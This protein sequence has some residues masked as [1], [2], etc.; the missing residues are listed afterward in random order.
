[1]KERRLGPDGPMVSAVG[2]GGM[3][4][5]IQGR[6]DEAQA[7][8]TIHAALDAGMRLIDTADV[9]C[10]DHRDIGHNERLIAKALKGRRELVVVA[11]KGGLVRPDGAW[12]RDARP[13]Q[14]VAACEASLKALG[15]ERIDLYQLHA[16]DTD[17]P[18]VDSVGA[19]AR[20]REQ[21]KVHHVGLSNVSA[22]QID[23]A[24]RVVPINSVQNRWNPGDRSPEE[25]GVLAACERLGL[26][27]L[28]YSPFG[29]ASG[30]R[31]LGTMERLAA[32][33]QRRGLS[34]HRLVLA[35]MIAKSPVVIPI[36]GARREESV[37]DSAA[38]GALDLSASEV[39]EVEATF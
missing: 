39:A 37:R 17:V 7:I 32:L 36:P 14:L 1:M 4:L 6:P 13:E 3:Y 33:A 27:F 25:D 15:V 8:R 19:I 18:F 5:S 26:A 24:R 9:Y 30:A 12:K 10:H 22:E 38:A 23:E 28:P 20:L 29:G 11:T 34:P 31:S 21:G 35:W 16:P 2:L